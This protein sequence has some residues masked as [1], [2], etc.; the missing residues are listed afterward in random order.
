MPVSQFLE[1]SNCPWFDVMFVNAPAAMYFVI[2]VLPI[3]MTSGVS[4]PAIV[5]S[6]FCRWSVHDWYWTL[7]FQPGLAFSNALL[8]DATM[9]GQPFCASCWSQTVSVW[10]FARCPLAVAVAATT[11]SAIAV[12]TT[13]RTR[14]LMPSLPR[15]VDARE[16]RPKRLWPKD[17]RRPVVRRVVYTNRPRRKSPTP[18]HSCQEG[19]T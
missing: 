14:Y 8:A 1:L 4:L 17:A 19:V 6:N 3:S 11:P 5:A 15:V 18:D 9:S 10:A 13:A 16:G 12:A 7:T 2:S